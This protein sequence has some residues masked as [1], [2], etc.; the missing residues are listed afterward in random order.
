ME[1]A[2]CGAGGLTGVTEGEVPWEA[3]ALAAFVAAIEEIMATMMA[4]QET[5]KANTEKITKHGTDFC[6][7]WSD[8]PLSVR[9]S[10]SDLLTISVSARYL[11]DIVT[12]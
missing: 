8:W 3:H 9:S 12:F 1:T 2:I 4:T 7:A 6:P 5:T 11:V 10:F